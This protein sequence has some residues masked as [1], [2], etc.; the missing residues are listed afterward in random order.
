MMI[1]QLITPGK[2]TQ[3]WAEEY[4]R[5]WKDIFTVQSE[6]AQI[7]ASELQAV[8]T[9][10]EKQL[11]EKIPTHNLTAYEYYQ[12][13]REE[14][15][16]YWIDDD[17]EAQVSAEYFYN[18]A[19]E[20]DPGFARAYTGITQIYY[21]NSFPF[22]GT[23]NIPDSILSRTDIALSLDDQDDE[24]YRI[25]AQV[26]RSKGDVQKAKENYGAALNINPNNALAQ[27]DAGWFYINLLDD[28]VKGLASYHKAANVERSPYLPV[29]LRN[30]A[31]V[32]MNFGFMSKAN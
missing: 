26:Y 12:R 17:K 23:H 4:R 28:Y 30:L 22:R 1:V 14:H 29:I 25:R 9:E 10:E 24:A 15:I 13:G 27:R 21:E 3:I 19:L 18:K 16:K 2:E 8:I 11:I 6:V 20:E 31:G 7:I 32:Y 5:N